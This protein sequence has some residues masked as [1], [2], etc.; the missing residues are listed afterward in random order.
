MECPHTFKWIPFTFLIEFIDS[1][2]WGDRVGS[3]RSD[4]QLIRIDAQASKEL[5]RVALLHEFLHCVSDILGLHLTEAQV[6][7]LTPFLVHDLE[8]NFTEHS[9]DESLIRL[10][11]RL[12][13]RLGRAKA[14]ISES[15]LSI[16]CSAP[17]VVAWIFDLEKKND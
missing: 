9:V 1:Q 12:G 17:V 7:I 8:K 6:H 4:V 14:A 10:D 13:L 16:G 2:L 5:Q 15:I 11:K 3:S